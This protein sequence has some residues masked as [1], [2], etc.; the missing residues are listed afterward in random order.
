MATAPTLNGHKVTDARVTIP[1]WGVWYADVAIDGEVA[2]SGAATLVV[3]DLTLSGTVLSG[4]PS[5]GRSHFRVVGGEGGWGK[6]LKKRSYAN[7]AGVKLAKILGD[8]AF[9]VGE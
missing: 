3:A 6:L 8:A 1:A 4:G 9:E 2:L 5:T 7:D